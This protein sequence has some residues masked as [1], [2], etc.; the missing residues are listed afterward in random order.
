M[1]AKCNIPASV[2][3]QMSELAWGF[4]CVNKAAVDEAIM[5]NY[6]E[7]LQCPTVEIAICHPDCNT[8]DGVTLFPCNE[9]VINKITL[10]S[11]T[12]LMDDFVTYAFM[13]LE[14]N[15]DLTGVNAPFTCVWEFDT[16][17]LDLLSLSDC[18]L[19][20]KYKTGVDPNI[21]TTIKVTI[22]DSA[23]CIAEKTC[24]FINGQIECD[25]D[26]IICPNTI[27]LTVLPSAT[28]NL[29]FTWSRTTGD[30]MNLAGKING[31]FSSIDWGD[32][33]VNTSL[34]HSYATTGLFT[35][36]IYNSDA[37]NIILGNKIGASIHR[38][39]DV[40]AI[41]TT[42][43]YLH[44]GNNLITVEPDLTALVNLNKL[45][46]YDNQITT[47]DITFNTTLVE[48]IVQNNLIAGVI[49]ISNNTLLTIAEFDYNAITNIT[50]L[51]SCTLLGF[52]QASNNNIAVAE[53]NT[54][55]IALD[56]NGLNNGLALLLGQTPA[57]AP[58]GLG[59]TAAA[60]LVIK[61]WSVIT[62]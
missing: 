17:V 62:D 31:S 2:L 44:L 60:N 57:A 54:M 19:T 43:E 13:V 52:F 35:V 48:I 23:G 33:T 8:G 11:Y 16:N 3:E 6:I 21:I 53:I 38:I 34:S 41:P 7:F 20:T 45:Y 50:G 27:D 30:A 5:E 47:L 24:Y 22:T 4:T 40:A 14:A 12:G 61:G 15:G 39:T 36:K 28:P 56:T 25:D 59:A 46:L 1:A 32:G 55:L 29:V 42:V 58:T 9:F 49:D 51:I 26:Y 37:T 18:V 10:E